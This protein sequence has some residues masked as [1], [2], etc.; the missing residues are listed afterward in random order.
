MQQFQK[1][2]LKSGDVVKIKIFQGD[3]WLIL[4]R[5]EQHNTDPELRKAWYKNSSVYY[6]G[7]C[8]TQRGTITVRRYMIFDAYFAEIVIRNEDS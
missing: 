8:Y 3:Y 6:D 5:T 2:E 7:I 1:L 4:G